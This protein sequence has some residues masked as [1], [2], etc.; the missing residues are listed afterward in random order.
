MKDKKSKR[1]ESRGP[2]PV[3]EQQPTPVPVRSTT[4]GSSNRDTWP[5]KREPIPPIIKPPSHVHYWDRDKK[6]GA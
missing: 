1:D 4:T 2:D 5:P 6:K 3:P